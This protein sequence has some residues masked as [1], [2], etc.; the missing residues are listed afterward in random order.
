[1]ILPFLGSQWL[2]VCTLGTFPFG[3]GNLSSLV[4]FGLGQFCSTNLERCGCG[5]T[6][7]THLSATNSFVRMKKKGEPADTD[8]LES[9]VLN[10]MDLIMSGIPWTGKA[11]E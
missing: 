4:P 6:P 5:T 11:W 9:C 3:I 8:P 2:Q 1:M 10:R 7:Q